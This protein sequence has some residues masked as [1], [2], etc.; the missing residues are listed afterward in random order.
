MPQ[1]LQNR[2]LQAYAK[3]TGS[4]L[5]APLEAVAMPF[6][7]SLYGSDEKPR[8]VHFITSGMASL[9]ALLAKG[10]EV[11]VS[12]TGHEG[13]AEAVHLL[14]PEVTQ[15]A[16][17]MQ[18]PGTALRMPFT[19]FRQLFEDDPVLRRL[20]LRFVQYQSMTTTQL[21]ACNAQHE[22]E[23]RLARWLLMVHDRIHDSELPL[24]QEFLGQMLGARRTS[25]TIA[26]GVLQRAG[27][28]EYHRGLIR[29]LRRDKLIEVA[30]ECHDVIHRMH[31]RLYEK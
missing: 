28:I 11:E 21:V 4:S 13:L 9:V 14:G 19:R 31:V 16:C 6:K 7:A 3:Q 18:V 26:A 30:C 17:F 22:T 8:Y 1:P 5:T 20:V 2:L 29:I 10:A 12:M 25:V 27:I 23:Q 15:R 24:T